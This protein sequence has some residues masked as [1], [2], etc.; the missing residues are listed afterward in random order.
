VVFAVEGNADMLVNGLLASANEG[1]RHHRRGSI[2]NNAVHACIIGAL[3]VPLSAFSGSGQIDFF[4]ANS[5]TVIQD[6]TVDFFASFSVSTYTSTNGGSD[7]NEPMPVEGSQFWALN[8][9]FTEQETLEQ[10]E[11]FAGSVGITDTPTLSPGGSYSG[12]WNFSILYPE[13]GTFAVTLSGSWASRVET[14]YSSETATR[15]CWNIDPGGSNSLECSSWQFEYQDY[16]DFYTMS[17]DFASQTIHIGVIA[18]PI[19][20][21]STAALW[22][23]GLAPIVVM[24]SRRKRQ[25]GSSGL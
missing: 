10:V 7:L 19:P 12:S 13:T 2:V 21:L 20:E 14:Y 17:G 23:A 1:S 16:S 9:Y 8:W 25:Q 4:G 24:S 3:L 15:D 6:S 18:A 11:L 22:L 5:T